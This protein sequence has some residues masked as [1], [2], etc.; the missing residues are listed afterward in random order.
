MQRHSPG[1]LAVAVVKRGMPELNAPRES[2]TTYEL[3]REKIEDT[4]FYRKA[5]RICT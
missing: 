4:I 3:L 5:F 2:T 1:D